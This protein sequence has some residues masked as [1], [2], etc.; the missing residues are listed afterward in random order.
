MQEHWQ[1]LLKEV[2]TSPE[3]LVEQLHLGIDLLPAARRAAIISITHTKRFC[4]TH[5]KRC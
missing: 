4:G 3:E 5:A 1:T 2:I